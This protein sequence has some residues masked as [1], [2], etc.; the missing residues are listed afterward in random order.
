MN[1]LSFIT[2]E[3]Y[4]M[5]GI[6][7][8]LTNKLRLLMTGQMTCIVFLQQLLMSFSIFPN[9]LQ[10]DNGNSWLIAFTTNVGFV[11]PLKPHD[12]SPPSIFFVCCLSFSCL[13]VNNLLLCLSITWIQYL[14]YFSLHFSVHVFLIQIERDFS[15]SD[16]TVKQLYNINKI[17]YDTNN[18]FTTL[19]TIGNMICL[20][21]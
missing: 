3:I 2:L 20:P 7:Q 5:P 6:M 4:H 21:K 17:N 12:I 16:Q 14:F 19:L 9:T 8:A 10:Q 13:F 1:H 18:H 15:I 11:L